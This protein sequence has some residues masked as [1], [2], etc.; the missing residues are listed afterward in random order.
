[1]IH[2]MGQLMG[3]YTNGDIKATQEVNN[4]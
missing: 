2:N 3:V 4:N 1:L